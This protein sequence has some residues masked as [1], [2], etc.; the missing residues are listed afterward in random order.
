MDFALQ[1]PLS[2]VE[3]AVITALASTVGDAITS[4]K[5][6]AQAQINALTQAL[7]DQLDLAIQ[8][9]LLALTPLATALGQSVVDAITA[10]DQTAKT[11]NQPIQNLISFLAPDLSNIVQLSKLIP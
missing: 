2:L 10:V 11:L 5:S 7:D 1:N 8:N 4:A 6:I 3:D 9:V